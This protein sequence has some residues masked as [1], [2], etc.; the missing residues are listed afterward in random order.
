M[1]LRDTALTRNNL[2]ISQKVTNF[3]CLHFFHFYV[4]RLSLEFS[5][6]FI[7]GL[8]NLTRLLDKP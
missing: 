5:L 6:H 4:V 8:L 3:L 7:P 1:R 2:L